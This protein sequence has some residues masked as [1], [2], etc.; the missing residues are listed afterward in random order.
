MDV[1]YTVWNLVS[2]QEADVRVQKIT[3][4]T[5]ILRCCSLERLKFE[6]YLDDLPFFTCV[7]KNMMHVAEHFNIDLLIVDQ[8]C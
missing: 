6:V 4:D 5:I 2:L 1:I 8:V 7:P 3:D